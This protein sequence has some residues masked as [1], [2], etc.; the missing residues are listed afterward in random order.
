M[1]FFNYNINSIYQFDVVNDIAFLLPEI[2]IFIAL[3][4]I[5]FYSSF[6]SNLNIYKYVKI[7]Y[8]LL[9][10]VC[11]ICGLY[12]ILVLNSVSYNNI[13]SSYL[14][15]ND[16]SIVFLKVFFSL[17]LII[18]IKISYNY[19]L[20]KNIKNFELYIFFL[21]S[22]ISLI[23]LIMSYDFI[24]AYLS[25]ELQGLCSYIMVAM[26]KSNNKSM[27]SSLKYFVLGSFASSL[28]LLGIALIYWS[29]GMSNFKDISDLMQLSLGLEFFDQIFLLGILFVTVGL[30]FKIS[31][32]P[33]H[34]WLPDVFYGSSKVIVLFFSLLPKIGLLTLF[35]KLHYLLLIKSNLD[36]KHFYIYFII[37]SLI[38][39]ISGALKVDKLNKLIAYSSITH[40][41]F[42][43]CTI[44]TNSLNIFLIFI[45]I[46]S[47]ILISIFIV[48][49]SLINPLTGKSINNINQLIYL[50]KINYIFFISLILSFFSISGIPP[51]SGFFSK[52]FIF[53]SLVNYNWN[54]LTLIMLLFSVISCFY[55]LRVI[56]LVSFNNSKNW[57][58]IDVLDK[59]LS[60]ILGFS[61]LINISLYLLIPF[62][63]EI[64]YYII[65]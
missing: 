10:L 17:L 41:G 5:I 49:L 47:L 15:Y 53:L 37:L 38:F 6:Y 3:M 34:L 9:N 4:I 31:V 39:G 43:L 29:T 62:M 42:I 35:F 52:F 58:L 36:S 23:L 22:L 19:L 55:Y 26:N 50:K 11:L 13:I 48:F 59:N 8:P 60:Y 32:A 57:F 51:L 25:I 27:E 14:L 56:K 33:F 2:F 54:L 63:W 44:L 30:F 45:V 18:L 7:A 64:F 12:I 16:N 46:Y 24:M 40:M 65:H 61:I 20:C 1:S 28:L 21:I